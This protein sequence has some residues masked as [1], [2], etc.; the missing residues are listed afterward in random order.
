MLIGYNIIMKQFNARRKCFLKYIGT[1]Y[2]LW[3]YYVFHKIN[4]IK[5]VPKLLYK[6]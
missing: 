6:K 4:I 2:L 3:V 1:I 5:N